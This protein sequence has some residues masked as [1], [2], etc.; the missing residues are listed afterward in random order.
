MP[1]EQ[2]VRR[3][4]SILDDVARI[5]RHLDGGDVTAS[6]ADE[7]TY[8]AVERC[9]ERIAEAAR[10]IGDR[11]D[12]AYPAVD[13]HALRQFGS[14]LRHDYDAIEPG[15]IASAVVHRLPKLEAACRD[16]LARGAA[17]AP[18]EGEGGG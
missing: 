16:A 3:L 6:L 8:D 4:R 12:A 15:L 14:V 13:F 7:K 5:R 11:L 10:K 2:V 9:L 18:S 1:S 17:A